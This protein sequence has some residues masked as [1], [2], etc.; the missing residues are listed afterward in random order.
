[1]YFLFKKKHA[2]CNKNIITSGSSNPIRNDMALKKTEAP[3]LWL[4][5]P[6]AVFPTSRPLEN[7]TNWMTRFYMSF[8]KNPTQQPK[9]GTIKE[10]NPRNLPYICIVWFLQNGSFTLPHG[11][12]EN[13]PS[14]HRKPSFSGGPISIPPWSTPRRCMA[15]MLQGSWSQFREV[16]GL[17][18]THGDGIRYPKVEVSNIEIYL[19]CG[20]FQDACHRDHQEYMKHI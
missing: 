5:K 20:P 12:M 7:A 4:W 13:G 8:L 9:Q 16:T 14:L 19:K 1:M 10:Q 17:E 2:S 6:K 15:V 3:P 18:V 11:P